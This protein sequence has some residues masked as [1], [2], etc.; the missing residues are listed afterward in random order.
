MLD[1]FLSDFSLIRDS[2]DGDGECTFF[3]KNFSFF[4]AEPILFYNAEKDLIVYANS[5]FADEFSCT[6]D[7]LAAAKYSVYPLI[8]SE[9][10][11]AFREA[12]DLFHSGNELAICPDNV[13][14]LIGKG[15]KYAYYRVKV[16]KLYKAYYYIQLENAAKS[17]IP[18]LKNNTADQ[19]MHDAESILKFGFWMK[20]VTAGKMYWT[21]GMYNLLE[22]EDN[23]L[24]DVS[25]TPGVYYDHILKND[26][27]HRFEEGIKAGSIKDFYTIKFQLK[28]NKDNVLT[29]SEY[30]KIDYDEKGNIKMI[31]GIT[32]DITL[33]EESMQSLADY[34]AMMLENETFLNY[35]TWESDENAEKI[36]WTDG[37]YNIFG[38][39]DTDKSQVTVNKE[40]YEKHLNVED[41]PANINRNLASLKKEGY[42]QWDYPITDNN[43]ISK[44]LSTYAKVIRNNEN[45]VQKIIGTTRDVTQIRDHERTLENKILELNRSNRE[46]EEFAYVASHDLQE[47]LRKI[48]TFSQRLQLRFADKLGE[49]GNLYINRMVAAC[50]N[51]R[52]LIDNLLEFS[53]ISLDNSPAAKVDLLA[54]VKQ[55]LEEL[56]LRI[57]ETDAKINFGQ[58]PTIEAIGSQ[59]QQLFSNIITN[60]IKFRKKDV[61]L[62]INIQSRVLDV[63]E[64]KHFELDAS[65]VYHLITVKDNGV[66]FEQQYAKKIFQLFQRLQG[67]SEYPGTGIGL[68]ICKKIVANHKGLI[69]AES[70]Q[71]KGALFSIILPKQQD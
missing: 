60:S 57:A 58:L 21:K 16:R 9:D 25:L 37:M 70:E 45:E 59:M 17:A 23:D 12:M 8:N 67:K 40:L 35:G 65:K 36:Y 3:G 34:K 51:M 1:S 18:V 41:L 52:K 19:L 50:D 2:L 20:D 44:V 4:S 29:V 7:D 10:H 24:E 49:D 6:V 26:V 42:Y 39:N 64:K 68:S 53:K 69:F 43:G 66:G 46:L 28:T 38:Y 54:T 11:A 71:D 31:M 48:S 22:Y 5:M 30:A 14:R 56:D 15:K 33:Q 13:Y 61:P 27:Y 55:S 47:P 63:K 62:E 32:R